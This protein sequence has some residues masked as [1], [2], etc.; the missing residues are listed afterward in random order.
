MDTGPLDML[1]DS[2]DQNVGAITDGINLDLFSHDILIYEYRMLLGNLVDDS[3]KFV[4]ILVADGDLHALAAQNIGW[5]DQ[6]RISQLMGRF[7]SLFGSVNRMARRSRNTAFL[8]N[9][10]EQLPVLRRIHIFRGR[11]EN[12]NTHLHQTF[13]QLDGRLAA[14]LNHCPI[15]LLDVHDALH[16][17]RCQ[18]L[19]IQ[20]I[21]NI[22]VGTYRLRIIIYDNRLIALFAERP[23]TV[24]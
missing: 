17:L 5:T 9:L 15:R 13:R 2:R 22:E 23:G 4:H 20:L 3:D 14:E 8:Q 12:R 21:R 10:V 1:H 16:I 6:H 18:R 19:E 11:T 24:N 7:F